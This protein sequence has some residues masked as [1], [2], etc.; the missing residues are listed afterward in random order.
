MS[1]RQAGPP[2]NNSEQEQPYCLATNDCCESRITYK[3]G[4][5]GPTHIQDIMIPFL[6]SPC[7]TAQSLAPAKISV[8]QAQVPVD[9]PIYGHGY[10]LYLFPEFQNFYKL[11]C[12]LGSGAFSLVYSCHDANNQ[13]F[14]VKI[15]ANTRSSIYSS[16][17][18][19][20]FLEALSPHRNIIQLRHIF[21]A[22]VGGSVLVFDH[23]AN[24]SLSDFMRV[25]TYHSLSMARPFFIQLVHGLQYLV[26][27]FGQYLRRM[28]ANN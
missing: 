21:L 27:N 18:E 20:M 26:R 12:K 22:G 3:D 19:R 1:S 9:D 15:P 24:G 16:I 23:A 17:R 7:S 11:Q 28:A 5:L 8:Y 4:L 25:E 10:L 14:A 13:V 2:Q 6:N